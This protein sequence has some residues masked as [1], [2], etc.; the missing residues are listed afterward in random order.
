MILAQAK[1]LCGEVVVAL[2]KPEGSKEPLRVSDNVTVYDYCDRRT[3]NNLFNR[4]KVI[5]AR[6]GYTTVMDLLE[7]QKRDSVLVPTPNHPEQ[8]YLA[9]YHRETQSFYSVNQ[10]RLDL[11]TDVA[12][13]KE[14]AGMPNLGDGATK[15][16]IDRFMGLL[17]EGGAI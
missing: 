7:L 12:R 4:A 3:R 15:A 10:R 11:P 5:I 9:S 13:A 1:S 14:H 16:T 6:F 17:A 8:E 2:G